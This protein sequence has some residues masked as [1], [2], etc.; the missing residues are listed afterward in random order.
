MRQLLITLFILIGSIISASA[1]APPFD[2]H[3][4]QIRWEVVQNDYQGKAQSLNA[5]TITNTGKNILPA[6]GWKL[7]FN[8]SRDFSPQSPTGNVKV[9]HL[10]GDLFSFTPTATF[11]E[12]KPGATARIEFVDTDNVVNF[13][14]AP[15]GPYLVWDTQPDKGYA[16]GK[17]SIT[18]FKP[19]YKGLITPEVI[20][21]QNK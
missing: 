8:S 7:Y 11:A 3:D 6:S 14:D 5:I 2:A 20:Y 10:N 13:T 16:T 19:N 12:V 4:L 18:P 15:E 1:D 9:E 17:F 21:N